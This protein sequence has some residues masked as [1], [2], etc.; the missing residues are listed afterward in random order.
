[1]RAMTVS[2]SVAVR[3]I[4]VFLHKLYLRSDAE[5]RATARR[6]GCEAWHRGDARPADPV[7]AAGWDDAAR[8]MAHVGAGRAA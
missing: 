2:E 5:R 4:N 6:R 8:Y 1:M 3:A 7:E